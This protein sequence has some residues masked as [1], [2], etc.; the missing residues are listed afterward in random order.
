MI[1]SGAGIAPGE[2]DVGTGRDFS[3]KRREAVGEI[4]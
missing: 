3:Q 4:G 2:A 1:N